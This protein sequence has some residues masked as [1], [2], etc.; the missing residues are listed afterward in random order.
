MLSHVIGC[1]CAQ[2]PYLARLMEVTRTLRVDQLAKAGLTQ[3]H[4]TFCWD[5]LRLGSKQRCAPKYWD[6]RRG[7]VK[8]GYTYA[9]AINQV[10]D[11]YTDAATS[12][13][14]EATR[15]NRSL[16]IEQMHQEIIRRYA[17]LVAERA[18]AAARAR[19]RPARLPDAVRSL[20]SPGARQGND[21]YYAFARYEEARHYFLEH[22]GTE[23][24]LALVLQ[25]EY[26]AEQEP[27]EFVHMQQQRLTEW[28]I[29]FLS[30]PART[31]AT[32]PAFFAPD[33]PSNRVDI[34][35]GLA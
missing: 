35:R 3:I 29:E 4:L 18:S 13:E 30:R 32:L 26:I 17:A 20:D 11:D 2:G 19:G 9:E 12:A 33:A 16:S 15:D 6:A 5:N 22:D 34:L 25:Q 8:K 24:P 28:P 31:V 14:H 27:G 7:R 10:L 23:E 1:L 21:Y